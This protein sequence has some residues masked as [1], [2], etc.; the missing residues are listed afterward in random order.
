M[1]KRLFLFGLGINLIFQSIAIPIYATE[2]NVTTNEGTTKQMLIS[3]G[4]IPENETETKA[5]SSTTSPNESQDITEVDAQANTETSTDNTTKEKIVT[6]EVD[7]SHILQNGSFD[8]VV[9]EFATFS[10]ESF[11][12]TSSQE[13]AIV[14]AIYNREDTIDLSAYQIPQSSISSIFTDIINSHPELYF[15]DF[16]CQF[17]CD[18][19]TGYIISLLPTYREGL[20][21]ENDKAAFEAAVNK[22]VTQTQGLTNDFEKALVL[23][24]YLVLH[25]EY[26]KSNSTICNTAYGTLVNQSSV[27]QGYALA[28]KYLLD[29]VNIESYLV[30]SD[31]MNHAWNMIKLD[32]AYYHVDITWDDP[33]SDQFG[34]A[35]H[36]Y[37]LLSDDTIK[38]TESNKHY[39]WIVSEGG[40]SLGIT[41]DSTTYE[42][43]AWTGIRSAILPYKNNWYYIDNTKTAIIK[44]TNLAS[45]A[46]E[47]EFYSLNSYWTNTYLD[48]LT[49]YADHFF[50]PAANGI[51]KLSANDT[52]VCE[53]IV[54]DSSITGCVLDVDT[55]KYEQN[56][57][58]KTYSLTN[59][60]PGNTENEEDKNNTNT[61][62]TTVNI[63]DVVVPTNLSL[64]FN[65]NNLPV[66]KKAGDTS[67]AQVVS[68]NYGIV[69]KS[70]QDKKITLNF[71]VIDENNQIRFATN[72]EQVENA[73]DG[74][75]VFYLEAIPGTNIKINDATPTKEVSSTEL[76]DVEMTEDTSH[77]VNANGGKLAFIMDK[78]TY[79]PDEDAS[80]VEN[81]NANIIVSELGS[82]C[83]NFGFTFNGVM[84][85]N[86]DWTNLTQGIRVSVSY[87][88][89]DISNVP[90]DGYGLITN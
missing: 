33:T 70:S 32:G 11:S 55:L 10:S 51:Y 42:S 40:Q 60:V 89:E 52:S 59:S 75:Y 45:K 79:T 39:D 50:F 6:M 53:Q 61:T 7:T 80:S 68:L 43:Y 13:N 26:Q 31:N 34:Y 2:T 65:P 49:L 23:H 71:K 27:C 41:A 9:D 77:A 46:T 67:T 87:T 18:E 90:S 56:S 17:T 8:P 12:L 38:N 72:K 1:K 20:G 88:I 15:V 54:N 35:Q 62:P 29:K 69:Q 86:T 3:E 4:T 16:S 81:S 25:C 85:T 14:S 66:T 63:T 5:K 36:D 28:Y 64:A 57:S 21:F 83:S 44:N 76:N 58:I 37:F 30:T 74:S 19:S 22:A 24:D 48:S 82:Q 78:A 73:A 84:N 47:T